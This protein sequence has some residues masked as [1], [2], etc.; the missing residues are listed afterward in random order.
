MYKG[1]IMYNLDPTGRTPKEEIISVLKKAK[2]DDIILKKTNEEK[3][4]KEKEEK[5]KKEKEEK[6]EITFNLK[7]ENV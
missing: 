2:L 5:E 4:K 3:E 7:Q 1:S 6:G